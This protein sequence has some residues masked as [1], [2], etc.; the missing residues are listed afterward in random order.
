MRGFNPDGIRGKR[1]TIAPR[2]N[3]H[4]SSNRPIGKESLPKEGPGRDGPPTE[5]ANS[6]RVRFRVMLRRGIPQMGLCDDT[7]VQEAMRDTSQRKKDPPY[8]GPV[9]PDRVRRISTN[10]ES[11]RR[12]EPQSRR[13][14]N[15]VGR[16]VLKSQEESLHLQGAARDGGVSVCF[17][18]WILTL[19]GV[20]EKGLAR[21][22]VAPKRLSIDT[23]P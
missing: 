16:A 14:R 8:V 3:G 21:E 10:R 7:E 12:N 18:W 11:E 15:R 5:A 2:R 9:G 19:R 23:P 1:R 13:E 22:R 6:H 4:I 17:I 20:P